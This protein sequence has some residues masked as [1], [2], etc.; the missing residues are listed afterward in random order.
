MLKIIDTQL[1]KDAN[2][3]GEILREVYFMYPGYNVPTL[4]LGMV[5]SDEFTEL[6][7][8][9]IVGQKI[10]GYLGTIF[11]HSDESPFTS[12]SVARNNFVILNKARMY[13]GPLEAYVAYMWDGSGYGVMVLGEKDRFVIN[14]D[15]VLTDNWR[16]CSP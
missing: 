3:F 5:I 16:W 12:V 8:S 14:T 15:I 11:E 4:P 7:K 13:E 10:L 9:S 1:V 2:V 6:D